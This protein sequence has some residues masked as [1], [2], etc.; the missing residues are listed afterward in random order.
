V[1]VPDSGFAR[2]PAFAVRPVLLVADREPG[3]L[4]APSRYLEQAGF[5]VHRAST[6]VR[7]LDLLAT[8]RPD[9]VVLDALL[10]DES[11]FAL[12]ERIRELEGGRKVP[13]ILVTEADD[14]DAVQRSHD[15]GATDSTPRP[16]NWFVLAGRLTNLLEGDR[17]RKN[18]ARAEE[19]IWQLSNV[20]ELTGLPN[21]ALL[22]QLVGQALARRDRAGRA[23]AALYI[24]IDRFAQINQ[25]LGMAVAD[26]L[27]VQFA[28]RLERVVR[29]G[30]TLGHPSSDGEDSLARL[31]GD[32]FVVFLSDLDD[33]EGAA[34]A[35]RRLLDAVSGAYSVGGSEVFVSA[36][37]GIAVHPPDGAD[38]EQ[39]LSHAAAA[40]GLAKRS[41]RGSIHFYSE[42]MNAAVS[43]KL[44]LEAHLRRALDRGELTLHYQPLVDG[45]GGWVVG[46]EALLRWNS[47]E[48]GP[49][50]P[51]T[52][53]PV[54]EESGLI[55]PIG[56]WVLETACRQAKR[57]QDEGLKAGLISVNVSGVQL[58]SESFAPT[59]ARILAE[60]GLA[61]GTLMLE[62]TESALLGNE[63]EVLGRLEKLRALGVS[64]VIDDFGAGF[65]ALRF[66]KRFPVHALKIDRSFINGIARDTS[67][68]AIVS[69]LIA[70]SR[71]LRLTVVAEGVETEGQLRFLREEGCSQAQGFLFSRPLPAEDFAA[72]VRAGGGG[73]IRAAIM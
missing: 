13:I 34:R 11:G 57:W 17:A 9:L 48:L 49:V 61:P 25:S 6:A 18:H 23:V 28:R 27:L 7:T 63:E 44:T 51:S 21:R 31:S 53:I 47:P 70:M 45:D 10:P 36:S 19:Q 24:D 41:G 55:V 42:T 59:V 5:T 60:T 20:D 64:L 40:L 12:C 30:D 43:A 3:S 1:T 46:S 39:L 8:V 71:G 29:R 65:T 2:E 52:F 16:V 22:Q 62:L 66:L 15:A 32:E 68:G 54:A 56:A 4:I 72:L 73:E 38:A 35:T 67:D 33:A 37:V 69:A 58:A 14:Y 26:K 50:P